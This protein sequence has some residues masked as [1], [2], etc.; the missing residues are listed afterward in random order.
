MRNINS[1]HNKGITL[2]ELMITI[3]IA[4]VLISLAAPNLTASIQNNRMSAQVNELHAALN[5]ARSEAVKRN[6][7]VSVC[8]SSNGTS[9]TGN[10]ED[11]WLVFVDADSDGSVD[12]GDDILRVQG[13]L[14]GSGDLAFSETYVTFIN[15]GLASVGS[16]SAFTLCDARG[17]SD[18]KGL[19]I[20]TSGRPRIAIDSD[21]NGIVEDSSG[22]DL[23]CPS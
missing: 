15:N 14:N 19:L 7:N 23:V 12:V 21:D 10:W 8:R 4:A 22:T 6:D 18:A 9:C 16:S 13:A 3:A 11:G 1:I 5:V 2:I 17:A 20:G